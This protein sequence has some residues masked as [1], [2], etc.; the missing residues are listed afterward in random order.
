MVKIDLNMLHRIPG[1]L[2]GAYNINTQKCITEASV[3]PIPKSVSKILLPR[4]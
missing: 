3:K 2:K 4:L 1:K